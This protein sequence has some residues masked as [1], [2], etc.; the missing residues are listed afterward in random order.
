MKL[1]LKDQIRSFYSSL[2][3]EHKFNFW[4]IVATFMGIIF[5]GALSMLIIDNSV[6]VQAK[7]ARIEYTEKMLPSYIEL[8]NRYG[9]VYYD[10]QNAVNTTKDTDKIHDVTKYFFENKDKIIAFSEFLVDSVATKYCYYSTSSK[11]A[12]RIKDNNGQILIIGKILKLSSD[13]THYSPN[14]VKDSLQLL[15]KS[16]RYAISHSLKSNADKI[17]NLGLEEY[18]SC[19][20]AFGILGS[21]QRDTSSINDKVYTNLRDAIIGTIN[22]YPIINDRFT[23]LLECSF[24]NFDIISKDLSVSEQQSTFNARVIYFLLGLLLI[25]YIIFN[26]LIKHIISPYKTVN[27]KNY[28]DLLEKYNR[29]KTEN[30]LLNDYI[31]RHD[32][33]NRV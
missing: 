1:S 23:K 12:K 7:L 25:F 3:F 14:Q 15:I 9:P 26:I 27:N 28:Q 10:L 5:S 22:K 17:I 20:A 30:R 8:M 31:E 4:T 21:L 18:Q 11:D 19:S 32:M 2:S 24:S 16:P 6:D 13:T 29:I 33:D